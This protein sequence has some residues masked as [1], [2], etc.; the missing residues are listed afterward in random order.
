[1]IS[2]KLFIES[3]GAIKKQND[4]DNKCSKLLSKI[5]KNCFQANLLYDNNLITNQLIKLLQ[6]D[7]ND[8]HNDSWIKYFL[9]ELDFGRKNGNC[10]A[11]RKDRSVIDLSNAGKLYD[12]LIS[13]IP[14]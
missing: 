3:I 11:W 7:F 12:Y 6:V 9:W 5:Y 1:M 2:K 13:I 10:S 4:H 8:D 14:L